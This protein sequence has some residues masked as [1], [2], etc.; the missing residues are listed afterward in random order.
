MRLREQPIEGGEIAEVRM[1]AAVVADV[2]APVVERRRVDRVQP[3]RIDAER[4]QIVE[5]RGDAV[6]IADAVAVRIGKRARIDLIED[7]ALPPL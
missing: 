4:A 2:V 6:E 3:D 7:G 5:M 1:D